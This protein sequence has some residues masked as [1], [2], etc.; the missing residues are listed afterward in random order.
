MHICEVY[1]WLRKF[2]GKYYKH[3]WVNARANIIDCLNFKLIRGTGSQLDCCLVVLCWNGGRKLNKSAWGSLIVEYCI[4]GDWRAAVAC[5]ITPNKPDSR[6]CR[7]VRI[8]CQRNWSIWYFL[9]HCPTASDNLNRVPVKIDRN[10]MCNNAISF[11]KKIWLGFQCWER[12]LTRSNRNYGIC[13]AS[14]LNRLLSKLKILLPD[15][16]FVGCD[17]WTV[18]YGRRPADHDTIVEVCCWHCSWWVRYKSTQ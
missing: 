18:C 17:G 5:T 4:G 2:S 7:S 11:D 9:N 15:V 16:H 3:G 10:N 8:I 14:T 13:A 6:V 1:W 12:D